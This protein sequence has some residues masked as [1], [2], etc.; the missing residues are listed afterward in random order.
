MNLDCRII[1]KMSTNTT[2]LL[3][4]LYKLRSDKESLYKN[5][6]QFDVI[7]DNNNLTWMSR[8]YTEVM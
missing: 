6:Y 5:Q 7:N 8:E 2:V 3:D 4:F 1:K